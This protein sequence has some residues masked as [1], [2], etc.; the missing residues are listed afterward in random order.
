[1]PNPEFEGLARQIKIALTKTGGDAL[2]KTVYDT[3]VKDGTATLTH[4]H[5]RQT[6]CS[7]CRAAWMP[8]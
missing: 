7:S 3:K 4:I 8:V 6:R 1:M 2:A 5:H